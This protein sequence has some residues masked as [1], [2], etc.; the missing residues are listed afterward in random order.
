MRPGGQGQSKLTGRGGEKCCQR[1]KYWPTPWAC[2]RAKIRRWHALRG[3]C[4]A[5]AECHSPM[6]IWP[7]ICMEARQASSST[8]T[9]VGSMDTC[10]RPLEDS[11]RSLRQ[12]SVWTSESSQAENWSA[13]PTRRPGRTLRSRM[14]NTGARP[15]LSKPLKSAVGPCGAMLCATCGRDRKASGVWSSS[16]Q[17]PS[18]ACGSWHERAF[19]ANPHP[20]LWMRTSRSRPSSS[21]P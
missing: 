9:G 2:R 15:S 7:Q 14:A 3:L 5:T 8:H 11:E 10:L 18:S 12:A 21:S 13:S 19:W 4:V 6:A 17:T 20:S 16:P 1:L